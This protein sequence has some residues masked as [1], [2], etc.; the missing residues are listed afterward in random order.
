MEPAA[1]AASPRAELASI[2]TALDDLSHRVTAIAERSVGTN[3]D[4]LATDLF[5]AERALGQARRRLGKVGERLR[6]R[7]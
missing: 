5:E 2:T 3:L 6:T 7:D 4:W 1:S